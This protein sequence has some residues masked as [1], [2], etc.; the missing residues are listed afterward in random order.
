MDRIHI[1][2]LAVRC[3]IGIFPEER[4][5]KQDV[6]IGLTLACDC[7]PAARSDDIRDAVDYKKIKRA[8]LNMVEASEFHLVE[9][10]AERIAEICLAERKVIAVRVTVDKPGALRFAR[11]V[12]V[13]IKRRR[14]EPGGETP[15]A[16]A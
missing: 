7:R 3:I 9:T 4:R 5:E 8:V 6:I 11:G 1:R 15:A 12:A 13:E 14:N 16:D 2:E 10:L